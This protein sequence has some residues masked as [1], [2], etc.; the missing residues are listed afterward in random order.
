MVLMNLCAGYSRDADIQT[1][2]MDMDWGEE[3]EGERN[4]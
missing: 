2:F 4:G 3:G 1:R